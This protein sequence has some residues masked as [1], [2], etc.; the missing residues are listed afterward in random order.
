VRS[1]QLKF[2]A[3][4]ATLLVIASIG[5]AWI[6]TRHERGALEAE[7]GKRGSAL[8]TNLVGV[9]QVLLLEAGESPEEPLEIWEGRLTDAIVQQA[10]EEPG[11]VAARL[12]RREKSDSG[13]IT[14]KIVASLHSE[15]QGKRGRFSLGSAD[16]PNLSVIE[17]RGDNLVVAAPVVLS[18]VQVGEA[19]IELDLAVLVEPVVA[20][21]QRQL[22]VLALAVVVVGIAGG[23]GF[24]ALLVGPIRRLRSG[25]ERLASGDLATRVPPTSRDEVGE[26]TRAF[27]KMG[28]S[29][30]QKERIQRAFGRYASDYVLNTLLESPEGSELT[31]VE[32]EVTIVFADIRSFTRLSEGLKAHDV[33]ALLNEIFQ[34]ASDRL[35]VRG[36]TIDKFI[37]DSVM[38][39][40]GAPVPDSDHAIHA[41]RA[42]IDIVQAVAERNQQIGG[43]G[44][45]VQVGIGIHTGT[46]IVGTIGSDR[47]T[48]FT[49]V[50]DA[51]NVAHRL[52]KLARPGEILVSEAVQRRVRGAVNL[53]FEGERQLSGR[54]EPVHVYSVD[55]SPSPA[56]AVGTSEHAEPT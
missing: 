54:V 12:I 16:E 40:F 15:E 13:E 21:S 11:V 3:L 1:L 2:S 49:A 7:V 25:V 24:V 36:G 42:A 52:E 38:A 31:G 6:A 56:K 39:Y 29:L 10:G 44:Y 8:A 37:G 48:D 43:D 34:L 33:V 46:V 4:V 51:V 53:R 30:L 45:R 41:V 9:A 17:R 50:G 23:I 26:L 22:A 28:E 18:G 47:R 19:Q 14:E 5:L 32:R 35:L 27:N 55:P 20:E